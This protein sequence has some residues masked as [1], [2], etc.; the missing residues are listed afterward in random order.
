MDNAF[1]ATKGL[2]KQQVQEVY[3][4]KKWILEQ[5]YLK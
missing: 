3:Y 1:L 4:Q 2:K 5:R